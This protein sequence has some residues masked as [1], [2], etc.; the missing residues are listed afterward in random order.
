MNSETRSS[1]S[2]KS[3]KSVGVAYLLWCILGWPGIHR[4]YLDRIASGVGMLVL[5]LCA[6]IS[7]LIP[8][9]GLVVSPLFGI[10]LLLWWLVDAFLIP[11]MAAGGPTSRTSSRPAG[12]DDGR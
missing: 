9:I 7:L 1:T 4:F 10:P 2:V 11:G 3:F 6:I 8:L 5:F 12:S